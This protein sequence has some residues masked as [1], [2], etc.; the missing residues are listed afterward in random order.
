MDSERA[1]SIASLEDGRPTAWTL[2]D[3]RVVCLVRVGNQV[4]GLEDPCSH[5][6]VPL[7]DGDMVDEHVIECPLH[8]AQFDVRT[9]V[10]LE[11]PAVEP[12]PTYDTEVVDG[13]VCVRRGK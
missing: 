6:D 7:S 1:G 4:Y 9:G 11:P 10:P 3:G 5:A 12:V 13:H 2:A 8:G